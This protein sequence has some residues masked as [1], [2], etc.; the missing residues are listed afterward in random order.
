MRKQF[1]NNIKRVMSDQERPS[2]PIAC[3]L[4][5]LDDRD[6]HERVA[7][8]VFEGYTAVRELED[9]YALRY[10]G[11]EWAE[12]LLA[13]VAGE[14]QCCPFFM[15]EIAVH[16]DDGPVWLRLRGSERV[17]SFLEQNVNLE[18]K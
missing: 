2:T 17:K 18:E 11:F 16:P 5:V 1:S 9:G 12:D 4:T 13:F 6:V 14:R 15:F 7:T 8:K 10:P 3:D